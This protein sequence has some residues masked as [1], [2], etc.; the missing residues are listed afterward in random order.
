MKK[1]L[2]AAVAIISVGAATSSFAGDCGTTY[3]TKTTCAPTCAVQK[4]VCNQVVTY[5]VQHVEK[6]VIIQQPCATTWVKPCYETYKVHTPVYYNNNYI[7]GTGCNYNYTCK[8]TCGYS[9]GY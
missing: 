7:Y 9:Y 2:L 4:P 8:P 3:I 6:R 1:L 5:P